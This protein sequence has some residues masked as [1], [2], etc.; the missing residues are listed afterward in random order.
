[1]EPIERNGHELVRDRLDRGIKTGLYLGESYDD[2]LS[3]FKFFIDFLKSEQGPRGELIKR[4]R[5]FLNKDKLTS[6]RL[7]NVL[8]LNSQ[9]SVRDIYVKY[10]NYCPSKLYH[11]HQVLK[12]KLEKINVNVVFI[13]DSHSLMFK[14]I[15]NGIKA[16]RGA[17]F[18]PSE[19]MAEVQKEYIERH[20]E[21]T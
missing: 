20:K 21:M 18:D 16:K 10:N 19:R 12:E 13:Q 5:E 14:N 8:K 15:E 7:L 11:Q 9:S 4:A 1:M 6:D 17:D 2:W 3:F